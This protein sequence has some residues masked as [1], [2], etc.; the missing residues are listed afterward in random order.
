MRHAGPVLIVNGWGGNASLWSEFSE[1]AQS[2]GLFYAS[3]VSVLD[4]NR[5]HSETEWL[6][7]IQ[8]ALSPD[9]LLIGWSL[10]GMLAA[11]AVAN[12]NQTE[13]PRALVLLNAAPCFHQSLWPDGMSAADFADFKSRTLSGQTELVKKFSYLQVMNALNMR[14]DKKLLK[15]YFNETLL[16]S[17]DALISGLNHLEHLS[18]VDAFK[19]FSLPVL[20]IAGEQDQ[21][22]SAQSIKKGA[23]LNS[24]R[25]AFK[26]IP[27]MSHLP[28]LSYKSP[29]L[30]AI[31]VFLDNRCAVHA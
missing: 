25:I 27:G 31:S 14:E 20:S 9:S 12:L 24:K 1:Q 17:Q 22:V 3:K 18:A 6:A 2:Q 28:A 13:Q 4:L 29:I 5:P 15:S 30:D 21:L 10:G 19:R 11:K 26:S 23:E 16:P 7:C 8:Q